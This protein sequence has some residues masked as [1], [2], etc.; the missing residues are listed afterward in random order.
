MHTRNALN[1]LQQL[2]VTGSLICTEIGK[3]DGEGAGCAGLSSG[4]VEA[5]GK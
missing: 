2:N 3:R 1:K 5:D 4:M